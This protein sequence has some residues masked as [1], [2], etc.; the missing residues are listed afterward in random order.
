MKE[1]ETMTTAPPRLVPSPSGPRSTDSEVGG[2]MAATGHLRLRSRARARPPHRAGLRDRHPAD[3]KAAACTWGHV[4][5]F[6]HRLHGPLSADA[7]TRRCSIRSAGTTNGLPT[8][9]AC[10][11]STA[12]RAMPPYRMSRGYEPPHPRH[13]EVDQGHDERPISR[14]QLPRAVRGGRRGREELRGSLPAASASPSTGTDLSHHRRPLTRDL[15]VGVH[16]QC[17]AGRGLSVRAPG[18]VG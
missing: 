14:H 18:L 12:V 2:R 13:R 3:R 4:F 11:T 15:P 5:S 16:P 17:P 6:T 1:S 8:E 10:R 7:G 9:S